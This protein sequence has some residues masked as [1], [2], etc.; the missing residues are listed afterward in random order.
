MFGGAYAASNSSGGGKATASAKAKKGPRGP[1][2]AKGDTGP[3]GPAGPAGP[4]G[5]A[6]AKGDAGANGTSGVDGT[7]GVSVTSESFSGEEEPTGEPCEEN[8]GSKF[9]SASP[10]ASYACNGS[11]WTAGGML[12]SGKTETGYWS[13][14]SE[15]GGTVTSLSFPVPLKA[16]PTLHFVESA[17]EDLADCPG[18]T[19]GPFSTPAAEPG[20]L[21][22][23]QKQGE[24][25]FSYDSFTSKTDPSGASLFFT[26]EGLAYGPWAVT[27]P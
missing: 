2:G 7:D 11:P 8:G 20:Q 3:A 13:L 25:G 12:P 26:G 27:A 15:V 17:G 22:I 9:D 10:E 18:A 24:A 5:P 21:C 4:Q 14:Y 6:G 23:Y 1:K 19:A 16:A